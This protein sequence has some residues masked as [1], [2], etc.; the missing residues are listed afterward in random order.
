MY[1]KFF[2]RDDLPARLRQLE[3]R[4]MANMYFTSGGYYLKGGDREAAAQMARQAARY[5]PWLLLRPGGLHKFLYCAFGAGSLYQNSR[6]A[7]YRVRE[8]IN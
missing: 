8:M 1:R 2:G 3:A 5:Y 4:A 6:K 7:Y